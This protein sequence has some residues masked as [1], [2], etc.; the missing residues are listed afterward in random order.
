MKDRIRNLL[1][2][3]MKPVDVASTVGCTPGYI[4]QLCKDEEFKKS[5]EALMIQEQ[6]QNTEEEHL[7]KRYQN[8]E[9]KIINNIE[10]ELGNAELPQLVKALEVV[11]KRQSDRRKEKLPVPAASIN[12]NIHITQIALPAHALQPQI[13]VI[14]TNDKNE[15]VA[16]G[17]KP[18]APMSS[19]GV[20]NIFKQL[21]DNKDAEQK[22]IA[23]EI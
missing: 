17:N 23:A 2:S 7:D 12:T 10:S 4:A 19:D 8:L 13:P 21:R 9:H 11:G 6:A 5:V 22:R 3:G 1:A 14:H 18:L 20:R 16:I 15:I